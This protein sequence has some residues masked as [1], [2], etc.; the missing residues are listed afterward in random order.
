MYFSIIVTTFYGIHML[1]LFRY[2]FSS[3]NYMAWLIVSIILIKV[4][5]YSW[6]INGLILYFKEILNNPDVT[7]E[8]F[9]KGIFFLCLLNSIDI[10]RALVMIGTFC[11]MHCI[12]LLSARRFRSRY[13]PSIP[14]EDQTS[15]RDSFMRDLET[16][17]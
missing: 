10:L 9:S 8:I 16:V 17:Y 14:L 15:L 2:R 1:L 11:F 12:C 3:R 6:I 4:I 7:L 5:Y 13:D